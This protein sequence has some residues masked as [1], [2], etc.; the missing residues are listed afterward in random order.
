LQWNKKARS[1]AIGF[2]VNQD[3]NKVD[4]KKYS[5]LRELGFRFAVLPHDSFAVTSTFVHRNYLS[6]FF[7]SQKIF[8]PLRDFVDVSKILHS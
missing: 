3:C 1:Y 8:A 5:K 2:V 7:A 4:E 6:L